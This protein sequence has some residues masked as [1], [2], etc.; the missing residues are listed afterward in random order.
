MLTHA[1][2]HILTLRGVQTVHFNVA[3]HRVP[4]S[5]R[6]GVGGG[7]TKTDGASLLLP[8]LCEVSCH[9]FKVR[10]LKTH[11]L[12]FLCSATLKTQEFEDGRGAAVIF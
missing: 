3:R 8:D 9:F 7:S 11:H 1:H 2:T 6:G 4:K 12:C 10:A 5:E